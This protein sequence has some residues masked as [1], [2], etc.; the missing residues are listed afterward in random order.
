MFMLHL[1]SEGRETPNTSLQG[2][3]FVGIA[4][5]LLMVVVGWLAG[6]R[7]QNQPEVTHEAKKTKEADDLVKIEG[8]G[9][10]VAKILKDADITTFDDLAHASVA[11]V[12]KVLDAA[13]FQMMNPEGWI[14]QAK[15]AA[16][17]NWT[18][19][20][21]MQSELKGGRKSK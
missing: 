18:A 2:L 16:N 10:K 17:E 7:K 5:F 20:E 15:L 13:G 11:E 3:L 4:F 6:S 9:P 19:L 21:K 8:I 14:D 12:K 1:L